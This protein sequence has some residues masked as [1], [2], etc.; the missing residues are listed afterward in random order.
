MGG[1]DGAKP[2]TN[3]FRVSD[4]NDSGV[5][6]F[7]TISEI[8]K[9]R[10]HMENIPTRAHPVAWVEG[11]NYVF[12]DEDKKGLG[13]EL[14]DEPTELAGGFGAFLE[15]LEPFDIKTIQLRRGQVKKVWVDPEFLKSLKK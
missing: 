1:Y 13:H 14:P 10:A 7:I 4:N 5:N 11:G 12:V 3:I 9:A 6:E 2:E 15:L 8:L